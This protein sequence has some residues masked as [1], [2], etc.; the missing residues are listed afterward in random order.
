[1]FEPRG[2]A[3]KLIPALRAESDPETILITIDD[4]VFYPPS[5]VQELVDARSHPFPSDMQE[6]ARVCE[7]GLFCSCPRRISLRRPNEAVGFSGY[8][9]QGAPYR[10]PNLACLPAPDSPDS[11]ESVDSLGSVD[12]LEGE[13]AH[14]LGG[15][16]GVA[17]RR[18]ERA[19]ARKETPSAV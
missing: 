1:M 12:S 16:L 19:V 9:L 17:Y 7:C 6:R 13:P 5:L 3:T 18:Q 14:V 11:I 2:P 4:D 10:H 8:R 15:V